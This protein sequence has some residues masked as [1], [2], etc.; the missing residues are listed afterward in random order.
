MWLTMTAATADIAPNCPKCTRP[1]EIFTSYGTENDIALCPHCLGYDSPPIV[2]KRKPDRR[3]E[4]R[5]EPDR[6]PAPSDDR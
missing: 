2:L 1:R 3:R 6:E 4:P 5:V